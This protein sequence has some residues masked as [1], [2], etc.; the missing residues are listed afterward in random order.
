MPL[1]LIPRKLHFQLLV[2]FL[3]KLLKNQLEEGELAFLEQKTLVIKVSDIG[4]A[5]A[6][7]LKNNRL[8]AGSTDEDSDLTVEAS[9]YDFLTLV[10]RDVDSDTLVF[11]RRLLMQ[12]DTES[13][14]ELKNVLDALDI[15]STGA[16]TVIESMLKKSLPL[17]RYLFSPN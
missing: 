2:I 16:F 15:E 5:Y 9:L 6:I 8:I 13:G 3:N 12:G 7:S 14:L 4:I 10:A 1:K 11:Q 17:Y